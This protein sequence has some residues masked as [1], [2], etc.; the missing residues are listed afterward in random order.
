[1]N[2]FVNSSIISTVISSIHC[3]ASS[4]PGPC[5]PR[6]E[7]SRWQG[8]NTVGCTQP[9]LLHNMPFYRFTAVHMAW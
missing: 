6:V 9:G 7:W 1:M 2:A 3:T 5:R 4:A 8:C